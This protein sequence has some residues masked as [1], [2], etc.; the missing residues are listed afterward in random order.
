MRFVEQLAALPS[1]AHLLRIE[2]FAGEREVARI[3]NQPGTAGSLR[4]YAW[5][6]SRHGM[7]DGEA[8]REGLRLYAEHTEDARR[9]P[10]KH[11][12]IDRLLTIA[13]RGTPLRVRIIPAE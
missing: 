1:V 12:N 7:I 3:E 13:E 11:P 9:H 10:G 2:L 5:L 6:A 4:I 8:A